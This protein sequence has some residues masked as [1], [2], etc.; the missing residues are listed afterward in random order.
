MQQQRQPSWAFC[1]VAALKVVQVCQGTLGWPGGPYQEE[2]AVQ[3]W[4]AW[5]SLTQ[6]QLIEIG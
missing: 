6:W 2:L 4:E 3:V 1:T 5:V